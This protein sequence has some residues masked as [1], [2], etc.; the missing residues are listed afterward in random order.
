MDLALAQTVSALYQAFLCLHGADLAGSP[1]AKDLVG[2]PSLVSSWR[3]AASQGSSMQGA[4]VQE[5]LRL[6]DRKLQK[7]ESEKWLKEHQ[8][9]L[10][11]S[12]AAANRFIS[13]AIPDLTPEQRK[14]LRK[15]CM[16]PEASVCSVPCMHAA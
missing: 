13:A 15:G 14:A 2:M 5:R 8:P 11:V 1:F 3:A 10:S 12:V 4:C 7:A 9:S 16:H 6:Y